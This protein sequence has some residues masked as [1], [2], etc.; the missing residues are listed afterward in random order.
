MNHG[1]M[2]DKI[3]LFIDMVVKDMTV[4]ICGA[5]ISRLISNFI[6]SSIHQV[7]KLFLIFNFLLIFLIIMKLTG[8]TELTRKFESIFFV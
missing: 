5:I 7:V 8:A 3:N 2:S 6:T 4:C 1:E